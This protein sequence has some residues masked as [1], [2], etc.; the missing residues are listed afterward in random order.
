MTRLLLPLIFVIAT[1]C[2]AVAITTPVINQQLRDSLSAELSRATTAADSLRL[3]LDLF[4]A[5]NIY[6]GRVYGELAYRLATASNDQAN[7]YEL[8]GQ[9]VHAYQ[10]DNDMLRVM[11]YRIDKMP[12]GAQKRELQT[13]VH[14]RIINN[15]AKQLSPDKLNQLIHKITA[16]ARDDQDNKPDIYTKIENMFTICIYLQ[17]LYNESELLRDYY[18]Q[19]ESLIKQMPYPKWFLPTFFYDLVATTFSTQYDSTSALQA[20][21]Q[22]IP[23]ILERRR[24]NAENGHKYRT[25]DY[26]LFKS[27]R[28]MLANH[29]MLTP[30]EIDSIYNNIITI[31]ENNDIV[32]ADFDHLHRT[33]IYYLM[34]REQ[35]GEALKLL[36]E[37]VVKPAN[38]PYAYLMYRYMLTA[39][40]STGDTAAELYAS[41]KYI[42]LMEDYIYRQTERSLQELTIAYRISDYK[43]TLDHMAKENEAQL[44]ENH[45]RFLIGVISVIAIVLIAAILL[46]ILWR[47]SKANS[48]K[49]AIANRQLNEE[50]VNLENTRDSLIKAR[51]QAKEADRLKSDF[52]NLM[53]HQVK[54]PLESIAEYSQLIVDCMDS[55]KRRYLERFANSVLMNTDLILSLVNDLTEISSLESKNMNVEIRPVNIGDVCHMTVDSLSRNV[56]EDINVVVADEPDGSVPTD[57]RR[58]EQILTNLIDN[59]IKF[60]ERGTVTVAYNIDHSARKLI[61]SVSDQGPGIPADKREAIFERFVQLSPQTP[62]VGLGLYA[63][64]LLAELLGGSIEVDPNYDHGARFIVT[65]PF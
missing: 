53:S 9:L 36:K 20:D 16:T 24:I 8:L 48:S 41:Q 2:Q 23:L 62:G 58:I 37:A 50:R 65:I 7:I 31:A 13:Y 47:R 5:S 51:D 49:L 1:V 46:F 28:R 39:A 22:L 17:A 44:R 61:I 63:S 26:T 30:V 64:R 38:K 32:K 3:A 27:Y 34:S 35:Y 59:A 52:I 11:E 15:E 29:I 55:D 6:D 21:R 42:E 19:L 57:R 12:P 43:A 10:N 18:I 40:R 60:A 56:P 14:L 4:D 54:A 33:Q 25:L 45:R